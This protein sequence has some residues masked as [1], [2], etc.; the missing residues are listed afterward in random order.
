MNKGLIAV[1]SLLAGAAAGSGVTYL[2]MKRQCDKEIEEK[3]AEYKASHGSERLSKRVKDLTGGEDKPDVHDPLNKAHSSL[4]GGPVT[5]DNH[6]TNYAAMAKNYHKSAEDLLAEMESPEDD[7]PEIE[8]IDPS[9]RPP[10]EILSPEEYNS[11]SESSVTE[12]LWYLGDDDLRDEYGEVIEERERLVGDSL[13]RIINDNIEPDSEGLVFVRN[14]DLG[15]IYSIEA[16]QGTFE[17][18]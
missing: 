9:A 8:E 4:E 14:N 15:V 2:V 10:F 13:S 6:R 1:L 18:N 5:L 11:D 12:L 7:E 3:I 16:I 17:S